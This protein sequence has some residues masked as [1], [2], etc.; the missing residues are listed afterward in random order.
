MKRPSF[1]ATKRF[2][3]YLSVV[4]SDMNNLAQ[5]DMDT[6]FRAGIFEPNKNSIRS[7]FISVGGLGEYSIKEADINMMT[8]R[9]KEEERNNKTLWGRLK[10]RIIS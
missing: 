1:Q 8:P 10:K 4:L 3:E 9:E 2:K 7:L 5:F 6:D